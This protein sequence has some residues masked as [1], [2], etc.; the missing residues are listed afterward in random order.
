MEQARLLLKQSRG[1]RSTMEQRAER[2]VALA[3]LILEESRKRQTS[4]ERAE[5]AQL[6]SMLNDPNGKAFVTQMTDQCF[7]SGH[8]H[9]TADQ[10][11]FLLHKFGVPQYLSVFKRIQLASF[12]LLGKVC[13]RLL[14]PWV[15]GVIRKQTAHV[16]I[17]GEPQRLEAHL[18]KRTREGVRINL[19]HLGEAILGEEEAEARLKIYLEDLAKPEVEVISVKISTIFSQINHL[20]WEKTLDCLSARL[21]RLYRAAQ[22]HRFVRADGREGLKFVNLDMEEYGDLHLTVALFQRILDYP[23][24]QSLPAGIVLQAYLPDSFAIQCALTEWAIK[25]VAAGGAQ[26]KIRLVKGANL[27]MEQVSASLH[28]WSQAPYTNKADVDANFK[29]MV[30]Y[31]LDPAHAH[32]VHI[33]IGSHNLFDIALVLLLRAEQGLDEEIEFEMLEGMADPVRWVLQD[34]L[35]SVLLYCPSATKEEFQNA[36]AYLIR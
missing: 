27:T 14:V 20:S 16:I 13:P 10:L 4:R 18:R 24:F 1:L 11:I 36:V 25:R 9:R 31:A 2:A 6:A 17:P 23:E 8:A 3:A 26:I 35:G 34:L 30:V 5:Q 22:T 19:N 12:R 7:R 29:K 28:G 32:A 15:K 33:G 21:T